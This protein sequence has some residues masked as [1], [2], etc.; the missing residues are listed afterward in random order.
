MDDPRTLPTQTSD[1]RT[2]N[3]T[4]NFEIAK[5]K[6]DI[7]IRAP[8]PAR[9]RC[10]TQRRSLCLARS[11]P[12]QVHG[13]WR[14]I[15]GATLVTRQYDK[16]VPTSS[17]IRPLLREARVGS[18]DAL[19]QVLAA[20]RPFLFAIA[21]D[22]IDS[23]LKAKAGPSDLVQESF[24]E[25][26]RDFANF[27]SDR[28]SHFRGWLYTIL[29]NNLADLRKRYLKTAKRQVRR[30]RPLGVRDSKHLL[31]DI[32]ELDG[33]SASRTAISREEAEK[34]NAALDRLRPAFREVIILRSQQRK[35]FVEIG[36]SIGKSADAVRMLW[37]RAMLKLRSEL[38]GSDHDGQ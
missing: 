5:N 10:E 15:P 20:Y 29:M 9:K 22:E 4:K 26:Q 30:E 25:A 16:L 14:Q 1:G 24:L 17:Q 7:P 13:F 12:C 11:K 2:A 31:R 8:L 38:K 18:P 36:E 35:T 6:P 34:I 28:E 37:Q 33:Q 23:D 27:T 19:G 32:G 3:R 21:R